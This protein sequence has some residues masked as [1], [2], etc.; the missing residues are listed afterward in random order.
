[1]SN[2]TFYATRN[3]KCNGVQYVKGDEVTGLSDESSASLQASEAISST[4]PV[5]E[6][7]NTE[8]REQSDKDKAG[9]RKDKDQDSQ[10]T[11]DSKRPE[12]GGESTDSGEGSIDDESGNEGGASNEGGNDQND[13]G[14]GNSG[15]ASEKLSQYTVLKKFKAEGNKYKVGEVVEM[16]DAEAAEF[17]EGVIEKIES[18]DDDQSDDKNDDSDVGAKL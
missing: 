4:K 9:A 3:I 17:E 12:V 8:A 10:E 14:D 5:I 15:D 18:S 7:P 16:T 11:K 2:K 6:E 1:M 13:Q